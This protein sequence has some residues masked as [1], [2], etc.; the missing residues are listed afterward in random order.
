MN[1]DNL[2]LSFM[3]ERRRGSCR[4]LLREDIYRYPAILLPVL[5]R[6]KTNNWN[7]DKN[8]DDEDEMP[9]FW[10]KDEMR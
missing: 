5:E 1:R 3:R 10:I 9:V 8:D 6:C 2:D 4:W 7:D